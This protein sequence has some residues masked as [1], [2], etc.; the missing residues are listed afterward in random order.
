VRV[1]HF[2]KACHARDD[3]KR[4]QIRVSRL[5]DLNDPF[6]LTICGITDPVERTA[7][8]GLGTAWNERNGLLCF[9]R[10]WES[11]V[12]WG[13]YGDKHRGIC[14]GIDIQDDHVSQI[15]YRCCG[16]RPPR[17]LVELVTGPP[18]SN[19]AEA[20]IRQVL[21]T[22]YREWSYEDEVRAFLQR[23]DPDA[24]GDCWQD[25]CGE[26]ALK[27]V[28]AGR[29]CSASRTD[30][31]AWL[32]PHSSEVIIIKAGFSEDCTYRVVEDVRGF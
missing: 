10:Q 16:V 14:L 21:T 31:L 11:P 7:A 1:Y 26:F 29:Y 13:H 24:N 2:L 8:D 17:P 5:K 23:R 20:F 32:G 3:L 6:E 28:I 15:A 30:I 25:F 12:L 27:E 18:F 4:W 22:K 19:E 9:S